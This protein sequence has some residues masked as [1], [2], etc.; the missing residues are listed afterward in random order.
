M[1]GEE[2]QGVGSSRKIPVDTM[3]TTVGKVGDCW[4]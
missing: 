2:R 3:G 1:V 4:L